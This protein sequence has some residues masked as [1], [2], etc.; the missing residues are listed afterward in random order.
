MNKTK[1]LTFS[2]DDGVRQDIRLT[3][4][5]R[6]YGMKATFNLNSGNLGSAGHINHGGFDVCFDK[7]RPEEVAKVYEGFEIA[8]HT[9]TH[10]ILVNCDD[11]KFRH[12]VLDDVSSL[13]E[14]SGQ[15]VKGMA[16]PCGSYDERTVE[17]LGKLGI[18]YSRTVADTH[19]F[20]LPERLLS[21]HPTCHDNDEHIF[22]LI[23]DFLNGESGC[24]KL[25]YIWGHAFELDKNDRDRWANMEKICSLL[26]GRDDIWYASNGEIADFIE[27]EK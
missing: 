8:S 23:D 21:W 27:G 16:Y 6:K 15:N 18:Q 5:F 4:L 22:E 7:V 12:E 25:F 13:S 3:E 19:G 11:A 9:V 24:L 17:L 10:P 1:A 26:S 20:E 14:L 2:Y